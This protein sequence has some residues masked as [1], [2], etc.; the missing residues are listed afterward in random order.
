MIGSFPVELLQAIRCPTDG[1]SLVADDGSG[2]RCTVCARSFR[3]DGAV[4]QMGLEGLHRE[5]EHERRLRDSEASSHPEP[6]WDAPG[7]AMEIDAMLEALRLRPG[8]RV[9]ELGAGRGRFTS[10]LAAAG[11]EVV[12]IDISLESL[13]A[14]SKRI[15]GDRVALL[16]GDAT[17]S[18]VAPSTFDRVLGTLTSNLPDRVTRQASYRAAAH[19]LKP[20]GIFVCS[21]H[22]LGVRARL[23]GEAREARYTE[24]GIYR[25]LLTADDVVQEAAPFFERVRVRPICVVLPFA[26]R[27]RLPIPAIDRVARRIPGLR[28]FGTLLLVEATVPRR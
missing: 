18:T 22:Y 10:L 14:A 28:A 20:D 4:L 16:H 11:T 7:D 5:S 13:R 17:R 25:C 6:S 12:A 24:G 8:H 26:H 19:A 15:V 9:L 27:L 3:L 23:D 2:A 21:T 1:G